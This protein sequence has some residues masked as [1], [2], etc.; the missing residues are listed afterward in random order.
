[1]ASYL[2]IHWPRNSRNDS[3]CSGDICNENPICILTE[4]LKSLGSCLTFFS[5]SYNA[6]NSLTSDCLRGEAIPLYL[7]IYFR[8]NVTGVTFALFHK[9]GKIPVLMILLKIM[10]SGRV[11]FS[12]QS[13]IMRPEISSGPCGLINV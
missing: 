4:D 11:M 1:M 13:S 6:I 12:P 7:F 3:Y 5:S 8:V 10:L 2:D 9:S